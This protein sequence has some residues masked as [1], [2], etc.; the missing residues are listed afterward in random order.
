MKAAVRF[1]LGTL[2]I[3]AGVSCGEKPDLL[4]REAFQGEY[5]GKSVDLFTISDG[6]VTAQLSNFG[7]R[8]V[9][10]YGKDRNGHYDD[11]IVGYEN[12][13]RY[14][15][16]TGNRIFGATVGRVVNRIQDACFELDGIVY[17]LPANDGSRCTHGGKIGTDWVVWDVTES[18]SRSV[19]FHTILPDGQ[20][21][22]PGNLDISVR[23]S[24]ED[25]G[26]SIE[27]TATT[28]KPTL[29]NL[30]NHAYFNLKGRKLGTVLDNSLMVASSSYCELINSLPT[31][32]ILPVEGTE[33]DFRVSRPMGGPT[34]GCLMLDF[35][36]DGQLHPAAE[37]KDPVSGRIL[38]MF[39]DQPS[40]QLYSGGGF[41]GTYPGKD[42]EVMIGPNEL[43]AIEAQK[44]VDAIHHP[45]FP[46]I[47]LRPGETYTQHTVYRLTH[48]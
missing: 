37:M 1:F 15:N 47:I 4:P 11:I 5:N 10:F 40:V 6:N 23:Y 30:T 45:N 42:P 29:C 24:V 26:L 12:I 14:L 32:E 21:G 39:T 18:D 44:P 8:I 17:N 13:D 46:S 41:K 16:N 9:G 38:E 28:D 35:P 34:G 20:D 27:Y 19:T 31:G 7:A 25:S 48:E 3:M 36:M 2:A 33:K 22:F 43:M